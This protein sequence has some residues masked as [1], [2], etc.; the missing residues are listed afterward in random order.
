M[1][2]VGCAGAT[3]LIDN[4]EPDDLLPVL[5]GEGVFH[6]V[7][8]GETLGSIAQAYQVP[9]SNVLEVNDLDT[10]DRL[11]IGEVIFIP[12][13]PLGARPLP[14]RIKRE[15]PPP[16]KVAKSAPDSP[17]ETGAGPTTNKTHD[18]KPPAEAKSAE[19]ADTALGATRFRWPVDGVLTSRFGVR[20]GRKHDGIDISAKE[21]T[22]IVAAAAGTVLYSGD[23]QR[24]YG[25]LLILRHADGWLTIYAH[26]QVN[27]VSEGARV[28]AGQPIAKVGRTGRADG[29]HL[30]FEVRQGEH[31]RNPTLFLPH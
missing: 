14:I 6:S 20:G 22:E 5:D 7:A 28:E 9:L 18:G 21:G 8:K 12:T 24:G 15:S 1:A 25:R 31:P 2:L 23:E 11:A 29:P 27:L 30:H 10:P 13:Q 4:R 19:P 17:K 26:N 3:G 16:N